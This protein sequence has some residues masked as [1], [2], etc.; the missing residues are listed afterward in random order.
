MIVTAFS[1]AQD[2]LPDSPHSWSVFYQRE[3]DDGQPRLIF[4]DAVSGEE[5]PMIVSG[6]RF[7]LLP[8]AVLFFD[9]ATHQ[10]KLASPEQGI[11][12]HPFIQPGADTLRI[13]WLIAPSRHSIVWTLTSGGPAALITTT[14]IANL[15]G[16]EPHQLLIDGP[17][18]GLRAAPVAFNADETTLY[19]DFQPDG[20]SDLT[21]FRQYAALIGLDAESGAWDYLPGEPGC[22]CGAGFGN[23]LLLRLGLTS[24]L[25][26]FDLHVHNLAAQVEQIIPA[27]S[28]PGYTQGGDFLVSASGNQAVYMLGQIKDFGTARQSIQ[29]VAALVDLSSMTQTTLISPVNQLIRPVAWT[30]DDTAVLFTSPQADGTWKVILGDGKLVKVSSVTYLGLLTHSG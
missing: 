15:D 6:E 23:G 27:L 19:M 4:V 10:V 9:T 22:F 29:T 11:L 1:A 20:I 21:P 13:D 26:G 24:D 25:S 30:E 12:N 3:T 2:T 17:R 7:T 5:R 14:T 28:L 18:N 8:D 16:T